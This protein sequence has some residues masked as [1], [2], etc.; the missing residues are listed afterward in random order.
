MMFISLYL[1]NFTSQVS[2]ASFLTVVIHLRLIPRLPSFYVAVSFLFLPS[3]SYVIFVFL[4]KR[5]GTNDSRLD[6]PHNFTGLLFVK[7]TCLFF[8][9]IV[10]WSVIEMP[11]YLNIMP[12]KEG[13]YPENDVTYYFT[14]RRCTHW[15][16]QVYPSLAL[17]LLTMIPCLLCPTRFLEKL[18]IQL[19]CLVGISVVYWDSAT[20][21]PPTTVVTPHIFQ[22][23]LP[24]TILNFIHL[25][26]TCLLNRFETG[27]RGSNLKSRLSQCAPKLVWDK[28]YVMET[29]FT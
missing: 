23:L 17:G 4:P 18:L 3:W 16:S 12:G 7:A 15:I 25:I 28:I 9:W 19:F 26:L 29:H 11:A 21:L 24:L 8:F 10:E 22:Y 20:K 14:M 13:D 5:P 1:T 27:G 6:S 2:F